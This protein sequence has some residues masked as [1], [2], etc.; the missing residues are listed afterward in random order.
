VDIEPP[1]PPSGVSTVVAEGSI[2]LIWEA[3][4][5]DDVAGYIVL[6]GEGPGATLLPVTPAPV[7]ETSF[8]DK[9]VVPGVSYVYAVVAVDGRV[10][11][12]NTSA[13]SGR[14]DETAR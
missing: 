4:P 11:L 2:S 14:V 5:S 8:V 6:R 1:Q 13:P 7:V 3:S 9:T 12:P 10:P